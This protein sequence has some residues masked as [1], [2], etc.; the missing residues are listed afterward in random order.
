MDDMLSKTNELHSHDGGDTGNE[1]LRM[2]G[3][4]DDDRL[5]KED[6]VRIRA[7]ATTVRITNSNNTYS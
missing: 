4:G 7:F 1:S 6:R 3:H 2:T 5:R